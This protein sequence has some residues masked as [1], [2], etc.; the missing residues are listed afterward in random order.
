M[1]TFWEWMKNKAKESFG[2]EIKRE[3]PKRE[4]TSAWEQWVRTDVT[5]KE[6]RK[7]KRA[8]EETEDDEKLWEVRYR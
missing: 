5:Q 1:D 2:H 3:M 8:R 4:M 7:D 6:G